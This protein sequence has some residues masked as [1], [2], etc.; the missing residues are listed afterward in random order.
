M[1]QQLFCQPI[2]M[3]TI[4]H[5]GVCAHFFLFPNNNLKLDLLL[6]MLILNK[7]LDHLMLDILGD[8]KSHL[9]RSFFL[10]L[11]HLQFCIPF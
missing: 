5:L 11:N 8:D 7:V 6:L 1:V 10:I 9:D 2:G 4:N 3:N